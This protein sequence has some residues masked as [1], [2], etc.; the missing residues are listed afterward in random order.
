[1]TG[2]EWV[3][4]LVVS[5]R[6]NFW[7][8]IGKRTPNRNQTHTSFEANN[9]LKRE[10]LKTQ[11]CSRWMTCQAAPGFS[12][13]KEKVKWCQP[14]LYNAKNLPCGFW[15]RLSR[16]N[17]E[18]LLCFPQLFATHLFVLVERQKNTRMEDTGVSGTHCGR[19]EV[20]PDD[21]TT[22]VV[23]LQMDSLSVWETTLFVCHDSFLSPGLYGRRTDWTKHH[24]IF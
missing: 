15:R 19:M 18:D 6:L 1:M 16:C 4:D 3:M 2:F 17:S 23:Y 12:V 21:L 24:K 7:V 13:L 14:A 9:N 20:Q 10:F 22:L 11:L 5:F 8:W